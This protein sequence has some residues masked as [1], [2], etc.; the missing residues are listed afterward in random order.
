MKHICFFDAPPGKEAYRIIS[1]NNKMAQFLP[2]FP[3]LVISSILLLIAYQPP[4]RTN[5][6]DN[7]QKQNS[8]WRHAQ[9]NPVYFHFG[10]Y[11]IKYCIRHWQCN[12]SSLLN[13]LFVSNCSIYCKANIGTKKIY[14]LCEATYIWRF[15]F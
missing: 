4:Q 2:V 9:V 11:G 5:L 10:K 1:W 12:Q 14:L 7:I 8:V 3:K 6:V 15:Y 13:M